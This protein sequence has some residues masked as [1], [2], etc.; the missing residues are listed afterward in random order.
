MPI[1]SL[2]RGFCAASLTWP[3]ACDGRLQHGDRMAALGGD[4]CGLEPGSAGADHHH[5]LQR[6]VGAGRSHAGSSPRGRSRRCGCTAPR[7]PR[8][9][10]RGNRWRRRRAGSGVRG[11]PSPSCTICGSARWAR[12]MP[13]MSSL[14]VAMAWRAVATSEMRAAWKTG[15]LVAALTSPAKS[16]CGDERMPWIGMTLVSAASVSIEPRMMLRK[17]NFP[18]AASRR[19][20]ST[21]SLLRQA[22]LEILVGDHADA[23]DEIRPD[24]GAHR[25]DHPPGEAQPVVER[26]AILVVATVGGG[27]PEAV[28]QMAVGLELDAVEAGRLHALRR[29]WHSRRRCARCPSPRPPSERSDAPAR[30]PARPTAPAASRPCSSRCGGRDG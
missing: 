24:G 5:L 1:S 4:A 22:L 13:T 15:N 29:R 25:V 21:P 6:A 26:A 7:R 9:C 30:A 20:I 19:A 27:R 14:P 12:V 3:P 18:D 23:D 28:H 17:S 2:R 16:R 8:R 10:G 11:P